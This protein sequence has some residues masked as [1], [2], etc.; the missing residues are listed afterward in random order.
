M[1][2]FPLSLAFL[3]AQVAAVTLVA[4][5]L[6]AWIVRRSPAVAARVLFLA[7]FAL[8]ILT[9]AMFCPLP[10]WWTWPHRA[11][12]VAVAES[13]TS[14]QPGSARAADGLKPV[15]MDAPKRGLSVRDLMQ[16][17]PSVGARW[18]P[19]P[20]AGQILAVAWLLGVTICGIRMIGGLWSVGRLRRRSR[21]VLDAVANEMLRTL[22]SDMGVKRAVE[23]R[24]ADL[25][26]LPATA[27]WRRPI[28]LLPTDWMSWGATELRSA[29]AHELA[30]IHAGDFLNGIVA[31]LASALHFYHPLPRRLLNRLRLRR[32]MAADAL[33]A[34]YAGGRREYLRALA[35]LALCSESSGTG[36]P[37]PLLLSAHG[38]VLFRRIQMLRNTEEAR[39]LSRTV[40]RL[41]LAM[42]AGSVLLAS[43]MRGSADAPD[44]ASASAPSSAEVE[45]FDLS[46]LT[47][48]PKG[49][50]AVVCLRPSVLFAQPGMAEY[51]K[52]M[53]TVVKAQLQLQGRT[54]PSDLGLA[55][56]E[57]IVIDAEI[58]V[59]AKAPPPNHSLMC[60]TGNL[61]I[62]MRRDVDWLSLLKG[63][64]GKVKT[65][66]Q[67]Q[68]TIHSVNAPTIGPTDVSFCE[69]DRR[70]LLMVQS[71]DGKFL[72]PTKGSKPTIDLGASWSQIERLP[73]AVGFDNR[74]SY[75]SKKLAPD[76]EG[77][78]GLASRTKKTKEG[79]RYAMTTSA[80]DTTEIAKPIRAADS[81]CYG[82]DFATGFECRLFL[83]GKDEARA[84][85]IVSSIDTLA[86]LVAD[87]LNAN[88]ADGET[89]PNDDTVRKLTN[90][91]LKSGKVVR[92]G[93]QVRAEG[94][95]SVKLSDFL[96]SIGDDAHLGSKQ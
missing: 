91:I 52:A 19:S 61:M 88:P 43:A 48:N 20:R 76:V 50:H 94:H 65:S 16:S 82:V 86:K 38:G 42:L 87:E 79:D 49:T 33:A 54:L 60:G 1:N 64:F 27:G 96:P 81:I 6:D 35:R 46:Y 71:Q 37:A 5:A 14:T 12:P 66:K 83:T 70:T 77:I 15:A 47:A 23:L 24:E 80:L 72:I 93:V 7:L 31:Q 29:L 28:I 8:P 73:F 25:P 10:N 26:G 45:P 63:L 18:R 68:F 51:A 85:E 39:P 3:A 41:T 2:E 44:S 78:T 89:G 4:L 58:T 32:E 59:D 90:D 17:L 62:R 11:E 30:H 84:R 57:Q 9:A 55:D 67:D 56:I 21:P 75:W 40:R 22:A 95:S 53:R 69:I 74:D 13:E 34:R 92:S 36:V